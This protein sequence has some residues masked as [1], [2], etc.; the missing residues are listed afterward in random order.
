MLG[1]DKTRIY[2]AST[3]ELFDRC[4]SASTRTTVLPAQLCMM[5]QLYGGYRIN[6]QNYRESYGMYAVNGILFNHE[7]EHE[8]KHS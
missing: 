4:R 3:S 6:R 1:L 8:A 2:Q 7:S 5:R